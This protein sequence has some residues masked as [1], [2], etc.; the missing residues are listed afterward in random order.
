MWTDRAV[1][2]SLGRLS[3]LTLLGNRVR[4]CSTFN[5]YSGLLPS[6]LF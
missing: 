1:R 6:F 4:L 2:F 3:A 5:L